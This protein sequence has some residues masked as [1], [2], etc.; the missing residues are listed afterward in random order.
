MDKKMR[1]LLIDRSNILACMSADNTPEV[2]DRLRLDLADVDEQIAAA[3]R[4]QVAKGADLREA[5]DGARF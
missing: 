1:Q 4:H 2:Q 5:R 3:T